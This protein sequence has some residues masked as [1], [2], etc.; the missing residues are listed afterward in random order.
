[1]H[2]L[3]KS[4]FLFRSDI[5]CSVPG[6][7]V[8]SSTMYD[9][10]ESDGQVRVC[11]V[12]Q[13]VTLET[14][15]TVELSSQDG[16]ATSELNIYFVICI[17]L[18]LALINFIDEDYTQFTRLSLTFMESAYPGYQLCHTVSITDDLYLESNE[19]FVVLLTSNEPIGTNNMTQALVTIR[20]D[21]ADCKF[22][23]L[24]KN[25]GALSCI[26]T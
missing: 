25:S 16:T 6:S 9:A 18:I 10:Y 21:P 5:L 7:I 1:M 15:I 8:L 3:T 26:F 13:E 17:V 22:Y 2:T 19:T 14:N 11:A 4:L 24:I 23:W 12:V 20:Q